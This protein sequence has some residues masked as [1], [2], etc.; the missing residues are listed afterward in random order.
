M[1]EPIIL[2]DENDD[3]VDTNKSDFVS[4][5]GNLISNI[6]YKLI[7]LVFIFGMVIFSDTFMNGVLSKISNTIDGEVATTKGTMIQ[8]TLIC[9]FILIADLLITYK[10]I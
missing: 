2:E 8:L 10:W 7:I 9:L 6:N 5:G 4:V 3:V 1:S